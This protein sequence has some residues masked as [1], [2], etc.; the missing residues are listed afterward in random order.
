MSIIKKKGNDYFEFD[1]DN[2][3]FIN[4]VNLKEIEKE[5]THA[6]IEIVYTLNGCGIHR[7]DDKEYHVKGGDMLIINHNCRH[8]VVP[9]ENLRYV[10]IMLKPEY[11]DATLKGSNDIFLL[12]R[13]RDFAVFSDM[14]IKDNLLIHFDGEERQKIETILEWTRVEQSK[15]LP[16]G[17]LIIHSMLSMLLSFVFRKMTEN[18]RF[19]FTINDELLRF[20]ERNCCNHL[21]IQEI[22]TKCG[23]SA[24]HFSRMFK[25]YT[26]VPP[27]EYLMTCRIKRA[28]ELLLKSDKPIDVLIDECGFS[29]RTAFFKKFYEHVGCTPLQFRKNQ[30]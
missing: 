20:M 17:E 22:A 13:F 28:K 21:S 23:Y 15:T 9:L 3:Y 14:V 24:E 5:H 10:D 19:R 12:L 16:A 26:G 6:F 7:V 11:V 27:A 30:K 2:N 8:T 25:K 29:D 18:Q 4:F 1:L